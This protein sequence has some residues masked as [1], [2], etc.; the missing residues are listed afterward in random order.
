MNV[1]VREE[2]VKV[3]VF[4]REARQVQGIHSRKVKRIT[5]S[6]SITI[7]KSRARVQNPQN[8]AIVPMIPEL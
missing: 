6:I 7:T 4:D 2:Q 3:N 8:N 5:I 1:F